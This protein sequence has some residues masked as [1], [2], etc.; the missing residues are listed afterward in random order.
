MRKVG[1]LGGTFDPVHKGHLAL[2]KRVMKAFQL[3]EIWFIP[4]KDTPLKDRSCTP[5]SVRLN[6]LKIACKP[7]RKFKVCTIENELP[8]PSYTIQTVKELKKRYP[9]VLFH[10]IVGDDQVAQ[11]SAWK[12]IDELLGMIQ[13]IAVNRN[14]VDIQDERLW[15]MHD[16]KLKESSTRVRQGYFNDCPKGVRNYI[17]KN[18]Y[19]LED[20]VLAHC[21]EKRA[22]HVFSMT[23]VCLALAKKHG[24]NHH[25]ARMA[26][27][28]HDICKEQNFDEMMNVMN[29]EYPELLRYSPKIFHSFTA[30]PWIKENM[31]YTNQKVL[32]AIFNHTICHSK[33]KLS[34][35]VF[36]ADKIDPSRGYDSS[37]LYEISL[38]NL[39]AGYQKV[40]KERDEY[41]VKEGEHVQ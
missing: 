6:M 31:G 4:T 26:G 30:I 38:R 1:C 14:Q 12:N 3:D 11:F 19:Y 39:E 32:R 41:L 25:E 7:Y 36:I 5:F 13:F 28:L 8:T 24:V 9:D 15:V 21:S 22:R 29:I 34:R 33:S 40:L 35:I 27:M 18:E 17:L 10:W 16:V 2:A 20:V 37:S 23:E